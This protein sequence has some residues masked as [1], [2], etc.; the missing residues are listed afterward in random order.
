MADLFP[1][2]L[3]EMPGAALLAG[4]RGRTSPQ[5]AALATRLERT[6]L[7]AAPL[8]PGFCC[9]G[10]EVALASEAAQAYGATRLSVT[11]NGGAPDEAL[12]ACLG[13]T[14][15]RLS[16]VG[17]PEDIRQTGA[18]RD[19]VTDGWIG[20]LLP[21]RVDGVDW[22][23]ARDAANGA[24]AALP[25]DLC[26]RRPSSQRVLKP[27]GALS[28]G[29]AAGPDFAAA[30]LRAGLEL[31][32]RDAAALWW[33][34]GRRPRAFPLEHPAHQVGAKLIPALRQGRTDRETRLLDIATELE[35]PA[36]AAISVD[37]AGYGLACGL[38]ARLDWGDAARA[39]ILEL[40]Q[41]ELAA[42]IAEAKRRERGDAA[43]NETDRGHLQRAAFATRGCDLLDPRDLA[44]EQI[45][46]A[47]AGDPLR[48]FVSHLN[49]RGARLFVVDL[50]RPDIDIPVARM[51]SPQLQPYTTDVV[52]E[53][54]RRC[55][56]A[57]GA[58]DARAASVSLF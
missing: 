11:G 5:L 20:E 22:M 9:L 1:F 41:M 18:V 45:K 47:P 33:L 3:R 46:I 25:A 40:C 42:P 21:D 49:T 58:V 10:G 56:A 8:A 35:I 23:P 50:T 4:V 28:V 19:P 54:L 44:T 32:E 36:V 51:V 43:L 57:N 55:R 53:R 27:A 16:H 6:F 24:E 12:I 29:V 14:A 2:D 34:G 52:T 39:A 13:E 37:R 48:A 15:D 26:V 30:A 31:C 17:R 7:I 38:A